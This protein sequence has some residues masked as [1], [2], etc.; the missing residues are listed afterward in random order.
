MA[1]VSYDSTSTDMKTA[2]IQTSSNM[3]ITLNTDKDTYGLNE[4]VLVEAIIQDNDGDIIPNADNSIKVFRPNGTFFT[5]TASYRSEAEIFI[6]SFGISPTDPSGFYKIEISVDATGFRTTKSD[7]TI[8]IAENPIVLVAE[9]DSIPADGLSTTTVT[10]QP[11]RNLEG[12][13]VGNGI[14]VTISTS[15][16]QIMAIDQDPNTE[17]IQIATVDSI[18]EFILKST[19][20]IGIAE[21]AAVQDNI[22]GFGSVNIEFTAVSNQEIDLI[23]GWNL[24]SLCRQSSDTSIGTVLNSISSKYSSVWAFQNKTW[25][26]YS[27]TNP[28][29]SDLTTLETGWGYW[30]HMME[31]ATLTVSGSTPFSSIDLI[32]GWNLVSY[33]SA[34]AQAIADA[35]ASI[36]GKIVSVWAYVNGAWKVYD[37]ANPGFSDLTTM[38]PGY[39]Y[40][41]QTT[42]ACT[43]TM[44]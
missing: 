4:K 20:T 42:E 38:G 16:G 22:K 19:E 36:S 35:L 40:W 31:S 39:G 37:P 34:T 2:S 24:I 21:I 23:Y 25:K 44:P 7:R 15:I 6:C 30:L 8:T 5:T 3:A 9:K 43:W 10:S 41:I 11:I 28:G 29:F 27:P 12:N 18:I 32:A 1:Y 17:G 33:N 14:L 26:V 13:L